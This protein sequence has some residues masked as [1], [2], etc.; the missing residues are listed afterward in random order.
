MS[1]L[2]EPNRRNEGNIMTPGTPE[3]KILEEKAQERIEK[4]PHEPHGVT[5]IDEKK[6]AE[7]KKAAEAGAAVTLE[8]KKEEK[9]VPADIAEVM[10]AHQAQQSVHANAPKELQEIQCPTC[11]RTVTLEDMKAAGQEETCPFCGHELEKEV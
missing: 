6:K 4:L 2:N 9:K 8:E 11:E 3:H 5:A 1:K 10:K 7:E